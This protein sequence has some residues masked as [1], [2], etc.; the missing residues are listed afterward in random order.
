MSD[1][2]TQNNT[3]EEVDLGQLF[4]AIGKIFER[5]FK[6]I[7]SIFIAIFSVI[8]FALKAIIINFKII[9]IVIIVAFIIGFA[10]EKTKEPVYIGRMLVEPYFES[11]YQLSSNIDYYNSLVNTENHEALA[12]VFDISAEDAKSLIN[13]NLEAGP[14]TE[15]AL[16]REFDEYTAS[17]DS[18]RAAEISFKDYKENRELFDNN[19]FLVEVKSRKRDIFRNLNQGFNNSFEN[20]YS[21]ILKNRR[22]STIALKRRIFNRNVKQL[23]SM[24]LVYLRIKEEESK[25]GSGKIGIQG[26]MPLAQ[27]KVETK[28]YELLQNELRFRDSLR[29]LEQEVIEKNMYYD[30]LSKFPEIGTKHSTFFNK[31][32][33]LFPAIAFVIMC[34]IFMGLKSVKYIQDYEK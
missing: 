24:K 21:K 32:S 1:Q 5:F 9:A 29:E 28:E 25:N 16:L 4:N 3:S 11:Q 17:I 27:E 2:N 12:S 23:D 30:V 7:G 6:F 10:Y 22:D 14:E 31:Y 26:M 18:S 34:L 19:T 13:F 20:D 33:L 8:V 15:N